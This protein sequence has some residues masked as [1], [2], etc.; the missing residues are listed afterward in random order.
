MH[1]AEEQV[2]DLAPALLAGV[3]AD[4]RRPGEEVPL[5]HSGE[6]PAGILQAAAFSVHADELGLDERVAVLHR[7]ERGVE[8]AAIF[9]GVGVNA[10]LEQGNVSSGPDGG[11]LFQG[12]DGL[13]EVAAVLRELEGA[14]SRGQWL[15]LLGFLGKKGGDG[16]CKW[17]SEELE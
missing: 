11:A 12:G 13:L 15:F 4:H 10:R 1:H 14:G 3:A 6:H 9:D 17:W 5:A 16:G 7:A 8:P 2:D